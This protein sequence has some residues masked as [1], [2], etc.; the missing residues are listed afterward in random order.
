MLVGPK[1]TFSS[2][3]IVIVSP[4][5]RQARVA[6]NGVSTQRNV[7]TNASPSP[8]ALVRTRSPGSGPGSAVGPGA[9]RFD[10]PRRRLPPPVAGRADQLVALALLV[11]EAERAGAV[12]V[13]AH[14]GQTG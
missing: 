11:L 8:Y 6:T 2:A 12:W 7:A 3:S 5:V 1:E 4:S 13:Q 10:R 14:R 9:G